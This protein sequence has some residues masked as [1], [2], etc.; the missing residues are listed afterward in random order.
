MSI[1]VNDYAGSLMDVYDKY[2]KDIKN[3]SGTDLE[4]RLSGDLSGADADE[5]MEVCKEFEAYLTEQVFKAMQSTVDMGAGYSSATKSTM[6]Y[7]N[8]MLMQNYAKSSTET[9]G[10]GIA[11]MLYEQMKR[12]YNIK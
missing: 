5:L 7:V 12:N 10:L 8:D 3:S 6:E 11:Q 1:S 9:N 2:A 4:S